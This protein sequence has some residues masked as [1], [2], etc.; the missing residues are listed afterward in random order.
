MRIRFQADADLDG[1][2]LR[3]VHRSAPEIDIRTAT[4]A[5]LEGRD[6]LDVLRI[7][8]ASGRILISQDRRTMPSNFARFVKAAH[9][10]GVILLREGISIAAAIEEIILIWSAS[11]AEEWTDRL[12]WIPL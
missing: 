5:G 12:M 8:A 11:E 9:S 3:G 2:I 4:A 6:D 10:P 7:A 1:R